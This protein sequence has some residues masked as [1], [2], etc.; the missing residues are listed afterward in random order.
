MKIFKKVSYFLM[1]VVFAGGLF[2][3]C[4]AANKKALIILDT[5]PHVVHGQT[6]PLFN[7]L[8]KVLFTGMAG[9][10]FV[11]VK[12]EDYKKDGWK[13]NNYDFLFFLNKNFGRKDIKIGAIGALKEGQKVANKTIFITSSPKLRGNFVEFDENVQNPKGIDLRVILPMRFNNKSVEL[14]GE[15]EEFIEENSKSK[16]VAPN[17]P[18]SPKKSYKK[19]EPRTPKKTG[20][21]KVAP[22]RPAKRVAPKRQKKDFIVVAEEEVVAPKKDS[23][24][25]DYSVRSILAKE[26]DDGP[27]EE[28]TL[29]DGEEEEEGRE[30]D[31]EE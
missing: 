25:F 7:N 22:K 15:V 31:G 28:L 19:K 30:E 26:D 23:G 20:R 18:K 27:E 3:N 1:L 17:R 13:K 14:L 2:T 6:A 8:A 9:Y 4:A 16:K 29:E 21:K 24:D 5:N 10:D 11:L 12:Q